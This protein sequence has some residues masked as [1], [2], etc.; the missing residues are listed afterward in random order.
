[1][2]EALSRRVA[3][4]A[5]QSR[6]TGS[7][8]QSIPRPV[9]S[10]FDV[11]L[12]FLTLLCPLPLRYHL[13]AF[14][15]LYVLAAEPRVLVPREVDTGLAC[16]APLEVTLK[17]GSPSFRPMRSPR[18]L[19]SGYCTQWRIQGEVCIAHLRVRWTSRLVQETQYSVS[20]LTDRLV[21]CIRRCNLNC[22]REIDFYLD[23]HFLHDV[24]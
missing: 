22:A 16:Y 24:E 21:K 15:H 7:R 23:L 17:V 13:Q 12:S 19:V 18:V 10:R 3:Q 11:A 6:L 14:R 5:T 20:I 1:M 8:A 2:K 9:T 4:A